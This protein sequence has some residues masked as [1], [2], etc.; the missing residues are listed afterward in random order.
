VVGVKAKGQ[1]R[2][3]L[4]LAS[5]AATLLMISCGA[6]RTGPKLIEADGTSYAACGGA[7]WFQNPKEVQDNEPPN[8]TVVFVDA[9]GIKHTL[10]KVRILTVNDLPSDSTACTASR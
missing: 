6:P 3:F 8:Y 9:R 4:A 7:V 1:S 10:A 5:C 2:C